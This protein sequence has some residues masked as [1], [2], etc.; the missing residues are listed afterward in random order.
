M[1]KSYRANNLKQGNLETK[2]VSINKEERKWTTHHKLCFMFIEE[3]LHRRKCFS[4]Q[5]SLISSFIN[6]LYELNK[7]RIKDI[8]GFFQFNVIINHIK[9]STFWVYSWFFWPMKPVIQ[10]W[11]IK[12]FFIKIDDGLHEKNHFNDLACF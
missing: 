5:C 6:I 8:D 3:R 11:L 1:W 2:L 10:S 4:K 12:L 9:I 7:N